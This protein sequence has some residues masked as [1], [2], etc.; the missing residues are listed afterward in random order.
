MLLQQLMR[1]GFQNA[2]NAEAVG[3]PTSMMLQQKAKC[4]LTVRQARRLVNGLG[5]LFRVFREAGVQHLDD[6]LQR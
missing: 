4:R 1:A 2:V 6:R 3:T 5:V